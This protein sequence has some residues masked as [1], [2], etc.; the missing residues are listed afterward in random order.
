MVGGCNDFL[1]N[2]LK[3]L[4]DST[5]STPFGPYALVTL[6]LNIAFHRKGL[7]LL[8]CATNNCQEEGGRHHIDLF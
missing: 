4:Y 2:L 7:S 1:K 6:L 5:L 8:I 3:N